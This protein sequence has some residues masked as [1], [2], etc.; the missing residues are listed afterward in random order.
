MFSYAAL[1]NLLIANI[2]K[3]KEKQILNDD[4]SSESPSG[5]VYNEQPVPSTAWS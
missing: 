2:F 5:H 1:I 4:S 3:N